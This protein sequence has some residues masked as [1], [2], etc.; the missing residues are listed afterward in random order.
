[1]LLKNQVLVQNLL[2]CE[3]FFPKHVLKT[4]INFSMRAKSGSK[5]RSSAARMSFTKAASSLPLNRRNGNNST[6]T[7]LPNSVSTYLYRWSN[8][9]HYS[10]PLD[11]SKLY[12]FIIHLHD[13]FHSLRASVYYMGRNPVF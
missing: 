5:L 9:H 12:R 10:Q 13:L 8:V 7:T 1:M 11:Q 2:N 4:K 3:F 6:Y